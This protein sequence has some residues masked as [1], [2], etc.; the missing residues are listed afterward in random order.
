MGFL[1]PGGYHVTHLNVKFSRNI[2][3]IKRLFHEGHEYLPICQIYFEFDGLS[4]NDDKTPKDLKM[5]DG[6]VIEAYILLPTD[7]KVQK[8]INEQ[9]ALNY[10]KYDF[11]MGTA[12]YCQARNLYEL[13]EPVKPAK[14]ESKINL[15]VVLMPNSEFLCLII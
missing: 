11:S 10:I 5:K 13:V 7:P 15:E 14:L 9:K 3:E 2:F 1:L 8:M 4:I 12:K 6:D